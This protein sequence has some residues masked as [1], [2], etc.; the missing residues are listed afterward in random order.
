MTM[1][2][3]VVMGWS[4]SSW[5]QKTPYQI[6][7][8]DDA[9]AIQACEEELQKKSPIVFAGECDRLKHRLAL[10]SHRRGFVLMG[11][12]C[13]ET[14]EDFA[15][16]R[17]RD[18][19]R[20]LLQMSLVLMYGSGLPVTQVA[21][22]AGQFAK[23]RSAAEETIFNVT[24]PVY[25]GD[26]INGASFDTVSRAPDPRR[27][28]DV[29]H[30]SVQVL[31]LIR[32]FIQGG[33]SDVNRIRDWDLLTSSQSEIYRETIDHVERCLVFMRALG[34]DQKRMDHFFTGHECL[35]LPY[36]EALTRVDSMTGRFMDCSAHFVWLG[37]RTR[38]MDSAQ[39]EFLSGVSNPIGIKISASTDIDELLYILDVLNP[40]NEPGRITLITRMGRKLR[41]SLPSIIHA[42]QKDNRQVLWCCDPMH[43]NTYTLD[44]IKTR[45]MRD[46]MHELED[47]FDIH[48][49]MGTFPGGIHLEMTSDDVSE[50]IDVRQNTSLSRKYTTACD[51]RLNANQAL[52][53]AFFVARRLLRNPIVTQTVL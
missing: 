52:E 8:Y 34:M 13:A 11:G 17:V 2:A 18:D 1:M 44:G 12:D 25:R 48:D 53:I 7:V 38:K 49:E 46:V 19:F 33:L 41:A 10:A 4:P 16:S 39:V 20:L 28:V 23:P 27:M 30:Q 32:A 47:F 26:M 31:N 24:L 45:S 22:M 51:P 50:C 36:E 37:E 21:R 29:Y 15:P 9:K 43:G 3:T 40:K 42:M 14:L 6:P 35:F 5:R